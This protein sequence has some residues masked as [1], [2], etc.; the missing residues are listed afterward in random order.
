MFGKSGFVK[1]VLI[2][3]IFVSIL[4]IS[5]AKTYLVNFSSIGGIEVTPDSPHPKAWHR[6]SRDLPSNPYYNSDRT[7]F[8]QTGINL[9]ERIDN[10]GFSSSGED[11]H[12]FYFNI[13]QN[14]DVIVRWRGHA[15]DSGDH[16][17]LYFWDGSGWQSIGTIYGTAWQWIN[18]SFTASCEAHILAIGMMAP[19]N[20]PIQQQ[21]T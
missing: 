1:L 16:V 13:P 11:T 4:Q 18:G 5:T 6:D 21:T 12:H 17:T 19:L 9:I 14:A 8:T 7:P 3:L 15:E 2:F 10:S 20:T